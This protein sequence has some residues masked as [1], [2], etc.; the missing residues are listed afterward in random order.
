MAAKKRIKINLDLVELEK[1]LA[2]TSDPKS[3]RHRLMKAS[4]AHMEVAIA[5][6]KRLIAELK[7]SSKK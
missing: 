7:K 4:G 3:K 6:L 2:E 1:V 5:T